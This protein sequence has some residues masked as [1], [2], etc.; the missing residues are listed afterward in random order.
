MDYTEDVQKA[1]ELTRLILPA[2]A[3]LEVPVNPINY[4]LWYEYYLGRNEELKFAIEEIVNGTQL[5]DEKTAL[6]LFVSHVI[7]PG[8]EKMH[9]VQDEARRLLCSIVEM[10]VKAGKDVANYR[11]SLGQSISQIEDGGEFSGIQSVVSSLLKET[12]VMMYNN[13]KFEKHLQETTKE[14]SL[15]RQE[16][17]EIRQRAALDPLTGVAN[18]MTFDTSLKKAIENA[19]SDMGRN[20]CLLM[21]DV[22]NFKTI[23]DQY[24][25]L[26][27]DKMLKFV[28]ETLKKMVKGKDLVARYGGD[29]FSIILEDTPE[30]GAF[31]L[32]ENIRKEIEKSKLKRIATGELLG[33][34]TVSIGL[35]SMQPGDDKDSLIGRADKA[36]YDAKESGRNTVRISNKL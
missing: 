7:N 22:D 18:R 33:S 25:H 11:D 31:I 5:Y 6:G 2:L 27:G 8:V 3:Q 35:A 10:T 15:L 24:G 26:I 19:T 9:R 17:S 28:S 32:A 29:E 14:M 36:L 1:A 13:R 23:N 34:Y 20:L 16:L 30:S 4:A 21:V 12:T